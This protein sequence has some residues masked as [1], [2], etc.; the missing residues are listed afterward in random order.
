VAFRSAKGRSFAERK[1][2][3]RP[4][5]CSSSFAPRKGVLSRSERRQMETLP[6]ISH[7]VE[8]H[9]LVRIPRCL[10]VGGR[11]LMK[12]RTICLFLLLVSSCRARVA[13]APFVGDPDSRL[14][15]AEIVAYLDGKILPVL[16]PG[17]DPLVIRLDGIE[18][19]SVEKRGVR[20]D[21]GVWS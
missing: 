1:A 21:V 13:P 15:N 12:P 8:R 11:D 2:T 10:G 14:T 7:S 4:S 18:A 6:E 5:V 19:L 3:I 20:G 16:K 9:A 17:C